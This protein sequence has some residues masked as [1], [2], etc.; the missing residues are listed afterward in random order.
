[1]DMTN[2]FNLESYLV[3]DL[4]GDLTI[5]IFVSFFLIM[6][7]CAKF[8]IPNFV[9]IILALIYLIMLGAVQPLIIVIPLTLIGIMYTWYLHKII[10]I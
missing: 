9:T 1:M 6:F 5:L 8:R 3:G 10:K 4:T 7:L 2:Y